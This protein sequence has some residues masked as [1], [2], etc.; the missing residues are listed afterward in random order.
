MSRSRRPTCSTRDGL[1][2][3]DASPVRRFRN[4][5]L[6]TDGRVLVNDIGPG[7]LY[8]PTSGTWTTAGLPTYPDNRL[9]GF[10]MTASNDTRWFEVDSATRLSDGRV[11]LTIA[12]QALIYD[13]EG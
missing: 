7:E 5:V 2:D 3:D 8:D 6:L 4:A 11:L 10:R 12:S 1:V 13:P 9:T